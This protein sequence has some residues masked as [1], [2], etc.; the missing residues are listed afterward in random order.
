[1]HQPEKDDFD[2]VIGAVANDKTMPVISLYFAGVYDEAEALKR[3]LPQKL[4]DQYAFKTE[5]AIT[6]LRFAEEI[7]K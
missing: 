1:M 3:L 5:K 6:A 2:V 4:K 7:S